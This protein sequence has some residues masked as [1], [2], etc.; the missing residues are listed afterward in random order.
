M[1]LAL[2]EHTNNNLA[3]KSAFIRDFYNDGANLFIPKSRTGPNQHAPVPTAIFHGIM[4]N[5]KEPKLEEQV[6]E[7]EKGTGGH[8]ECIEV[9]DGEMTTLF[10]PLSV[11]S[12]QACKTL[13]EH[14]VFGHQ[15]FNLVG[16]SQG[17]LIA[18]HVIQQCD[19]KYPVRNFVTIGA[20]NNGIEFSQYCSSQERNNDNNG[21]TIIPGANNI[22]CEIESRIKAVPNFGPYSN[23]IQ[24]TLGP[25][26]Y[27]RVHHSE[28]DYLQNSSFLPY[29]NNER[30]HDKMKM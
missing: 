16:L 3:N 10:S 28:N 15:Q 7:I 4:Q 22:F 13:K 2:N 14:P 19:L 27:L 11:Q 17:S 12:E 23:L 30:K 24:M 26:N 18:R 6:H 29:L 8:A 25:S 9:G 1:D 20:P 21:Q 5:C